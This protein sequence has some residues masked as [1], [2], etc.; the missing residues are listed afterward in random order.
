M[1][2]SGRKAADDYEADL[3]QLTDTMKWI[4]IALSQWPRCT[5][6]QRRGREWRREMGQQRRA[7]WREAAAE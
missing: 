2:A 6:V 7:R 3:K 1:D 4:G 5:G